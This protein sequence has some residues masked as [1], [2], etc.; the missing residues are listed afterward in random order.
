MCNALFL[1]PTTTAS[2][3]AVTEPSLQSEQ[4]ASFHD[5]LMR[6]MSDMDNEEGVTDEGNQEEERESMLNIT[7]GSLWS[8]A[9]SKQKHYCST[10]CE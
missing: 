10:S 2:A 3:P 6:L 8:N 1:G 4:P 5:T 9:F 7:P